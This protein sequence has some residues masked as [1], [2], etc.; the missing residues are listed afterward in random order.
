[1]PEE[2]AVTEAIR[3]EVVGHVTIVTSGD[4]LLLD[5][6]RVDVRTLPQEER[7]PLVSFTHPD[8]TIDHK[9]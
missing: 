2:L 3:V 9:I 5:R 1:M 6:D 4:R 7:A 8:G